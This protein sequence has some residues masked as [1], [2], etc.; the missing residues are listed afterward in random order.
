MWILYIRNSIDRDV[1]MSEHWKGLLSRSDTTLSTVGTNFQNF[2]R[3]CFSYSQL[4]SRRAK[5]THKRC[6]IASLTSSITQ[7]YLFSVWRDK[8]KTKATNIVINHYLARVLSTN[9]FFRPP[10]Y[11]S[12][13]ELDYNL[14]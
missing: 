7:K 10:L 13:I 2:R 1:T 4:L 14:V 5:H 3:Y 6:K 8:K 12:H 11:I 9:T